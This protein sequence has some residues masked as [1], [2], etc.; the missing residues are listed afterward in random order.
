MTLQP[1]KIF[2]HRY[3]LNCKTEIASGDYC[4]KCQTQIRRENRRSQ[5]D[6]AL[7]DK[8]AELTSQ[9]YRCLPI[10]LST[11]PRPDIIG[12]KGETIEVF[13][14]LL[15]G[16]TKPKY[17]NTDVFDKVTLVVVPHVKIK[18]VKVGLRQSKRHLV[19]L[20]CTNCGENFARPPSWVRGKLPFCKR[21]C[22]RQWRKDKKLKKE[23]K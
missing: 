15:K 13:D 23:E 6:K 4:L 20:K 16:S 21:S 3:C 5:H 2:G 14:I 8:V 12:I 17:T 11:F 9:G 22:Y 19:L 7:M 18:R 1:E 10:G